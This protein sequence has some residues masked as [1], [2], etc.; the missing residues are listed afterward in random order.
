VYLAKGKGDGGDGVRKQ[1]EETLAG[2][3]LKGGVWLNLGQER[4]EKPRWFWL[5]FSHCHSTKLEL[6]KPLA[7]SHVIGH[8]V[9]IY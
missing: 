2:R 4:G 6:S 1:R 8:Y 7:Q 9:N 5:I 3:I